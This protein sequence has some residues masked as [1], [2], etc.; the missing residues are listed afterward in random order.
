[1]IPFTIG[2]MVGGTFGVMI[3]CLVQINR[4]ERWDEVS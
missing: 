3:L 2:M 4:D 1:M